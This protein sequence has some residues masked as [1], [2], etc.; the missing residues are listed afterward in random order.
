MTNKSLQEF[1]D[2]QPKL[3]QEFGNWRALKAFMGSYDFKRHETQK[4][5]DCH[6]KIRQ[7]QLSRFELIEKRIMSQEERII[8]LEDI[9][10]KAGNQR[11][12][13]NG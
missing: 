12:G 1:Y 11:R 7:R 4:I 13:K 10:C 2:N 6:K 8:N 3:Q 5:I 9:V